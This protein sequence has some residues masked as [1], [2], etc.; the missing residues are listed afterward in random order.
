M[1][2][3]ISQNGIPTAHDIWRKKCGRHGSRTKYGS[4]NIKSHSYS[5]I[6]KRPF[7]S[8]ITSLCSPGPETSTKPNNAPIP[9][10]RVV[11]ES[12]QNDEVIQRASVD[13]KSTICNLVRGIDE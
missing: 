5:Y 8:N 11:N 7:V 9:R 4:G 3:M 13:D 12:C 10:G 6:E 2:S 1:G